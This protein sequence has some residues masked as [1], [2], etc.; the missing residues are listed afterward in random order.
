MEGCWARGVGVP[1]CSCGSHTLYA[2]SWEP[3][4]VYTPSLSHW[5]GCTFRVPGARTH[6]RTHLW[7]CAGTY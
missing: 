5:V 6:V 7:A 3:H 4:C 1:G 2:W